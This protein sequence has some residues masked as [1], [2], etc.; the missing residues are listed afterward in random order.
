MARVKVRHALVQYTVENAQGQ[1]VFETAFR[2]MEIDI[3]DGPE[4]ER[5]RKYEAV[6]DV[7]VELARPGRMMVLPETA[8]DAEIISWVTGATNDEVEMLVRERP[9]MAPRIQAAWAGVQDRFNEQNL[10]LGG[11]NKIAEAARAHADQHIVVGTDNSDGATPAPLPSQ[12]QHPAV[13][14]PGEARESDDEDED[15]EEDFTA[16][17]AEEIV[18][19]SVKEVAEYVAENPEHANLILEAEGNREGGARQGVVRAAEAAVKHANQ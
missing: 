1:P 3:P 14:D 4:L 7:G 18:E 17:D 16:A 11:L 2:N 5:L 8:G 19:G 13:N 6:V 15:D 12:N 10:H 9:T